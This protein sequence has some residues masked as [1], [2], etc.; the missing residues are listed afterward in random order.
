MAQ[1]HSSQMSPHGGGG[2]AVAVHDEHAHPSPWRYVVVFFVL[3]IFTALEV[4]VTTPIWPSREFTQLPSLLILAVLKFATIAA[5]YMHLRFDHR[6]FTAFFGI[7]LFLAFSM[8][9]TLMGLFLA[10]YREPFDPS[11]RTEQTQQAGAATPA[12]G[13]TTAR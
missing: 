8:L 6:I 9:F 11:T 4:A 12:A 5:Y 2:A 1:A 10:H 7:G 3:F 13:A